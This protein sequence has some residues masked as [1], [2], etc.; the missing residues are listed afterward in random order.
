MKTRR[1]HRRCLLA[2]AVLVAAIAGCES[3]SP[4]PEPLAVGS[5]APPL[6]AEGWIH[7]QDGRWIESASRSAEQFIR[8]GD[9]VVIDVWA[10]SCA[11]CLESTPGLMRSYRKFAEQPVAF[12]GLTGE[13]S[14][15]LPQT[16]AFIERLSVP[17]PTGY[18]AAETIAALK[19]TVVPT[20]LIVGKNGTI[21]W[22]G[23]AGEDF[24]SALRRALA[25]PDPSPDDRPA[26]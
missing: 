25:A 1:M 19:A 2:V 20:L 22:H 11:P 16:K 10:Y 5:P 13:S 9:V 6:L 21:F 12:I 14:E 26:A 3:T 23:A 17:W 18:G 24:E 8:Q 4:P 15:A 7:W